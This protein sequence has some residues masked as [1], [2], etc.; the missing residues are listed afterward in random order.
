MNGGP[1]VLVAV[2]HSS[3]EL[4]AT[5]PTNTETKTEKNFNE[6]FVYERRTG[7]NSNGYRSGFQKQRI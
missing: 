2:D 4:L 1:Q 7:I 5:I 6:P 3:K